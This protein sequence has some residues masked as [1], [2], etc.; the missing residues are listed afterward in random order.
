[1]EFYVE[2]TRDYANELLEQTR[3]Y[4][5]AVKKEKGYSYRDLA[6]LSG[7][8][9]DTIKN[10]CS[11]KTSKNA[12]FITIIV[13]AMALNIDLNSLVG[14]TPQ[15]DTVTKPLI[16]PIDTNIDVIVKTY[17]ERIADI[18]ELCEER[19]ADVRKCCDIRIS[20]LKQNYEERLTEQK[21]LLISTLNK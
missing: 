1:M 11:G 7:I 3:N 6:N 17:E 2:S 8:S 14:Y 20:D 15:K 9:E 5:L 21:E 13:L 10:F 12:G 18:K 16:E 4:F 19:I